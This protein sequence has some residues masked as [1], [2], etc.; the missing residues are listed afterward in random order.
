MINVND[1]KNGMTILFEDNIYTV[2]EFSHVKPGKG[3]A[4]V[5]AKLKNLRTGSIVEKRFNSGVKL[6]KA[7]VEKKSMHFLYASGDVYNFMNMETYEQIE[8]T[9]DQIGDDAKFLKEDLIVD[10][11]FF[12]GELLGVILPEK[13]EMKVVETEPA[14]KG[15]TTN[16]A[17]KDAVLETG[18]KVRVPL[19]VEQGEMIIVSTKDGKYVSRK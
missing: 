14:V 11:T 16:N 3:A 2:L 19:F 12:Q 13:I 4:F 5:Q 9:K 17:L 7:M 10:V 8:I 6:E 18:L 15:N 1:I